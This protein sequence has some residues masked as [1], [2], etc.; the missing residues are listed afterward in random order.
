MK[1][2]A[3][4]KNMQDLFSA[5][6]DV[7]KTESRPAIDHIYYDREKA[8]IVATNGKVLL[9]HEIPADTP[10]GKE[11]IEE[12]GDTENWQYGKG[13]LTETVAKTDYPK[14][15]KCVPDMSAMREVDLMRFNSNLKP[16]KYDMSL[17]GT[18]AWNG[19]RMAYECV[20]FFKKLEPTAV[21]IS[22]NKPDGATFIE[23][24]G[25]KAVVM[26]MVSA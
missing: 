17:L 11:F 1:Y 19:V 25:F 4:S 22:K 15:W 12:L 18:F 23:G 24:Y 9:F 26:P 7:V 20:Q 2:I 16:V 14:W 10:S 6:A 8:T 21:Y 5:M 13:L 3:I